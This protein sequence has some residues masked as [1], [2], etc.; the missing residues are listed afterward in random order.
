M[1]KNQMFSQMHQAALNRLAG[2]DPKEIAHNAGIQYDAEMKI[3]HIPTMGINVTVSYPDYRLIPELPD[4]HSLVMLHYLDLADGFPLT[5]KQMPFG[6]LKSGMV[7]GDGIDRRCELAIQKLKDLSEDTL[8]KICENIGG[9]RIASNADAAYRIPFLPRF[10]VT[11]KVWLPDEEFP[12]SG[13]LLLDSGADHYLTIEDAV[14]V[15]E[16]MIE[17]IMATARQLCDGAEL[18]SGN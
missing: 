16:I 18:R 14:T 4:W 17:I 7:R 15:A 10:P 3:F 8:A 6:Q 2:R 5:G 9:E 12:A 11:L 1:V 13:R